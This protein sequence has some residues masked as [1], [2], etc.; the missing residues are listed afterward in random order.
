VNQTIAGVY[1]THTIPHRLPLDVFVLGPIFDP[2]A[3]R[4]VMTGIPGAVR[5]G[6]LQL[7]AAPSVEVVDFVEHLVIAAPIR[8]DFIRRIEGQP[9]PR[10][11]SHLSG[12]LRMMVQIRIEVLTADESGGVEGILVIFPFDPSPVPLRLV[13]DPDSPVQAILPGAVDEYFR[14]RDIDLR[15]GF[16][17]AVGGVLASPVIAIPGLDGISLKLQRG[18]VRAFNHTVNIGLLLGVGD[19][20]EEPET[21]DPT[22]LEG[23]SLESGGPNIRAIAHATV[24]DKLM[25]SALLSGRLQALADQAAGALGQPGISADVTDAWGSIDEDGIKVRIALSVSGIC[26]ANV[27][28]VY[29]AGPPATLTKKD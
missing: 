16:N 11:V 24:V 29:L 8:I 26:A 25:R 27:S 28:V 17:T 4:T 13:I 20:P 14:E 9:F 23:S 22:T 15:A 7:T 10:V 18:D 1:Q 5:A 2:D 21:G 3:L 12:T 19:D 6:D